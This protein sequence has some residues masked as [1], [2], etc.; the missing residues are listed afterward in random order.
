MRRIDLLHTNAGI[1]KEVTKE[2]ARFSPDAV[3]IVV[4]NPLDVMCH[5]A[6]E[7]SG[8]PRNRVIGMAGVLDSARFRSFVATELDVSVE[9]TQAFVLGRHGNHMIPVPR[10]STVSGIPI[11]ELLPPDRIEAIVERTRNGGAE[12]VEFLKTGSAYYAP[13]SAAVEMAEAVIK[14][15]KKILPCSVY[16]QKEYGINNVF[17]GVPVKLGSNGVED[18]IEIQLTPEEQDLL[19]KS[20]RSVLDLLQELGT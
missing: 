4:S 18:I 14:N 2:A 1:M 12:I 9:N 20:A 13:A 5:V 8:F 16:L 17:V 7:A 15:K 11:T 19:E 10:Y 3:L 6:L